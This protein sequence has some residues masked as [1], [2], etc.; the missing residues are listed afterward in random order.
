M[1]ETRKRRIV[2]RAVIV[3][4]CVVLL[5]GGYVGSYC[6]MYWL[7]GT[8]VVNPSQSHALKA[9][10]FAPLDAYI[11][12]EDAPGSH[13]IRVL[14]LWCMYHGAGKPWTWNEVDELVTAGEQHTV[15]TGAISD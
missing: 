9:T 15:Y 12:D 1:A 7:R 13:T 4:A 14:E 10:V 11:K 5:V 6:S 3:L 8:R 2:R